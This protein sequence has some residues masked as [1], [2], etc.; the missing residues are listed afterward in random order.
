MT[1]IERF[2]PK[3]EF[4]ATCWLWNACRDQLGYGSFGIGGRGKNRRAHIWAYEHFIGAIPE[5]LELD[6]LCRTRHCVNPWHLEP[7]THREN[8]LRGISFV[9][10]NAAK[11]HC[12]QGHPLEGDNVKILKR[13]GRGCRT[14]YNQWNRDY[15]R[16][17]AEV[18]A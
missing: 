4:T 2:I 16:R 1:A 6:H 14:C 9:A 8:T 11:T 3:V 12:K 18:A 15:R 7:V 17:N 13:G 5:G 10:L